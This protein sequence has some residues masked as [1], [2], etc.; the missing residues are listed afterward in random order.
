LDAVYHKIDL[1][2]SEVKGIFAMPPPKKE[3]PKKEE[4]PKTE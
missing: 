3:E 4:E 2:D 1:L